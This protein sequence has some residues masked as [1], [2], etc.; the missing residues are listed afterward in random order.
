MQY[1]IAGNVV[2]LG[3]LQVAITLLYLQI[4]SHVNVPMYSESTGSMYQ[5]QYNLFK[6]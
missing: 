1:L 4:N 2:T 6:M 3:P 5:H